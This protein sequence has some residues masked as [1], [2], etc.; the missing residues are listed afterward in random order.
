V[1]AETEV[2]TLGSAARTR[3][4]TVPFPAPDGPETTKTEGML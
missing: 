2:T 1:V 3:A 4:M